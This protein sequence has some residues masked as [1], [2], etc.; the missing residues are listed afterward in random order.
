MSRWRPTCRRC[1]KRYT[2]PLV[3]DLEETTAVSL[4]TM[5]R[6]GRVTWRA[7]KL[8]PA[9]FHSFTEWFGGEE[10]EHMEWLARGC[11]DV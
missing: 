11:K 2:A 9:C 7:N 6:N 3:G 5:G 4:V 1:G 8:C 10:G